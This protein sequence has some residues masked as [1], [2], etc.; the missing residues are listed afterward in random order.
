M[1][2]IDNYT[3]LYTFLLVVAPILNQY[4]IPGLNFIELIAIY[5][6][7]IIILKRPKIPKDRFL[8]YLF[9]GLITTI[10]STFI[11]SMRI[12]NFDFKF[13]LFVLR[14]I[15][16]ICVAFGI[17]IAS[18]YYFNYSYA[19][20]VYTFFVAFVSVG[21][22]FQL[23]IHY[24]TGNNV[25]LIIPGLILNYNDGINSSELIKLST[26]KIIQ[27]YYFRPSSIFLEPAYYSLYILPWISCYL[28]DAN[29]KFK[30][31]VYALIVTIGC[32]LT[33]SSLGIL[34][35][36][37][38]WLCFFV[39]YIKKKQFNTN[40]LLLLFLLIFV[41]CLCI[42][43]LLRTE[44]ISTSIAIKI[45][46][47]HSLNSASSTSVRLLRGWMFYDKLDFISK[48]IGLGYGNLSLFYHATGMNLIYDLNLT[49]TSYMCGFATI[50]NSF[51]MVGIFLYFRWLFNILKKS[52]TTT[53]M[54]SVV[55]CIILFTSDCY[56]SAFYWMIYALITSGY[57]YYDC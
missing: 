54:L 8:V 3:K 39:L 27:G 29:I 45:G 11:L 34:G 2:K 43:F 47:L 30:R 26:S 22:F 25:F 28:N 1:L 46:S 56:D 55:L 9:V 52:S 49:E 41:C 31:I 51:G 14:I 33:T 12:I 21:L 16:Y 10:F 17:G 57:K 32:V 37:I 44:G 20:K 18:K 5:G 36:V 40:S 24:L 48:I 15:K 38:I 7:A 42:V 50:I 6:L 35:C 13:S 53:R 23:I 4:K 19:K